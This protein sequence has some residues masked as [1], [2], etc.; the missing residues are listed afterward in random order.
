MKKLPKKLLFQAPP[1]E[2]E[3]DQS[4]Q[5]FS[6]EL[7]LGDGAFGQVWR[8]K[9]KKSGK[10]FACKQVAKEKVV[11][12]LEQFR[13]EVLI[14]YDLS[15]PN[16]IQIFHHF[17][18]HKYFYLIM[19]V[20]E[21][22]NLFQKLMSEKCFTE[23]K[24]FEY[25]R[26]VLNAV[27][28]L[29]SHNP[30]IIHRDIKPENILIDKTGNLK[31]TDFGWSNFYSQE[32]GNQRFTMCGTYEYLA[33]EMI[34]ETGHSPAVDIWCLGILLYEML[35]GFTPFKAEGNESVVDN[36]AKKKLKFPRNL[37]SQVKDLISKILEKNPA[38]RVQIPRIRQH[39]WYKSM[40]RSSDND[41]DKDKAKE[42]E[43]E[44]E[45]N[46][47]DRGDRGKEL[48]ETGNQQKT[49]KTYKLEVVSE[50]FRLSLSRV[51]K[52]ILE[53]EAEAK[54][55]R[56]KTIAVNKAIREA[57]RSVK[58]LEQRILK[59]RIEGLDLDHNNS[60]LLE[61]IADADTLASRLTIQNASDDIKRNLES[62][63]SKLLSKES[64]VKAAQEKFKDLA[65]ELEIVNEQFVDRERYSCQLSQYCK[66]L[67]SKG[68]GLHRSKA[69]QV[70]SLQV[71]R[72]FLRTQ[73]YE[74]EKIVE[75]TETSESRLVRE[76]LKYVKASS[77]SINSGFVLEEKI[78]SLEDSIA[79]KE[80]ETQKLTTFYTNCKN[81][82]S[83]Q[84]RQ[85]KDRALRQSF[86]I[87]M[88]QEMKI[89]ELLEAREAIKRQIVE[90]R[91]LE[92]KFMLG[93]VEFDTTKNKID[94]WIM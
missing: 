29:H 62:F 7:K 31:L 53:N 88:K 51:K 40:M 65:S 43:K 18:D 47:G 73:I 2:G 67:K 74:H 12:M 24:A 22:G 72:D 11:K 78:R 93:I 8:V 26:E 16:I 76:L 85:A 5:D 35:C 64:E 94:V 90:S 57:A 44:K 55:L 30:V 10:I 77:Q 3:K 19:E 42:K 82:I 38:K 59:K 27:E 13:R 33:P 61:Y 87:G 6:F 39:D 15:H 9:H 21:G 20:A 37:P 45:K 36:I 66:K 49:G 48:L 68:S 69:S 28:Y 91:S 58:V 60:E 54:E 52:G 83:K 41:K 17:E 63:K 56:E 70:S 23:K 80:L 46:E 89:K 75:L 71:S 1:L 14:M 34:K 79:L 86:E 81:S 4:K 50:V 25:F 32:E 92:K 84:A